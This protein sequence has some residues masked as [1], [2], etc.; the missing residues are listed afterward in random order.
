MRA[1]HGQ[2]ALHG[3][4]LPKRRQRPLHLY[5]AL[6]LHQFA[7]AVAGQGQPAA[8]G[9][10]GIASLAVALAVRQAARTGTRQTVQYGAPA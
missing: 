10:D 8:T 9:Q 5:K 7:R 6:E 3:R 1:G 2:A 4:P